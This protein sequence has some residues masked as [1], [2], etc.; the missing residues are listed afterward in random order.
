VATAINPWVGMWQVADHDISVGTRTVD[1]DWQKQVA[2]YAADGCMLLSYNGLA[3][4]PSGRSMAEWI[5]RVLVGG[6]LKR[7]PSGAIRPVWEGVDVYL[8]RLQLAATRD[9]SNGPAGYRSA[10]LTISGGLFT[11]KAAFHVAVGNRSPV[12]GVTDEFHLVKTQHDQCALSGDGSGAEYVAPDE[13]I[14]VADIIT[15]RPRRPDDYLKLLAKMNEGV[16]QSAG[17]GVSPWCQT[18]YMPRSGMP[19]ICQTFLPP[20]LRQT[21]RLRP[22]RLVSAGWDMT[23]LVDGMQHRVE[24]SLGGPVLTDR[25]TFDFL[26]EVV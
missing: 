16:A 5:C 17:S 3:R 4:T 14:R 7:R 18:A 25:W 15:R 12:V 8:E 23:A 26:P 22:L 1:R 11:E 24:S 6:R 10:P 2:I 20:G 19:L 21:R 9:F 13:R